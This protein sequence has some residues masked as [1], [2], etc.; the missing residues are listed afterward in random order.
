MRGSGKPVFMKKRRGQNARLAALSLLEAVLDKG[1]NLAEAES[2]A[3]LTDPRDRAFARYLAYGVL[4]WLNALDW[5][6]RHIYPDAHRRVRC[7]ELDATVR[8]SDR[9]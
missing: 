8:F 9:V 4:R 3:R 7:D 5:L 1:Q 6:A 2:G